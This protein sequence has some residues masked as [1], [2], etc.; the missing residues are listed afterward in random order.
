MRPPPS[1]ETEY[2]D[3]VI[4]FA[5]S[6]NDTTTAEDVR[7]VMGLSEAVMAE[8]D[9]KA[10]ATFRARQPNPNWP[11]EVMSDTIEMWEVKI[12]AK[13]YAEELQG[14][15]AQNARVPCVKPSAD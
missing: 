14:V 12:N 1:A 2:W 13:D 15:S 5:A 4:A 10:I 11:Y 8:I 7:A 9:K 6:A 3:R